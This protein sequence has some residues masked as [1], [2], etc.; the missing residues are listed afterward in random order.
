METYVNQ[1]QKFLRES[2]NVDDDDDDI[3]FEFKKPKYLQCFDTFGVD[4]HSEII[5]IRKEI[6]YDGSDDL[7][8]SLSTNIC[9]PKDTYRESVSEF[10]LSGQPLNTD[11][12]ESLLRCGTSIIQKD[13]IDDHV[14]L[15]EIEAR[16]ILS[17]A[18]MHLKPVKPLWILMEPCGQ[19]QIMI[20]CSVDGPCITRH[21]LKLT[22]EDTSVED[23]LG[24]HRS[25][26]SPNSKIDT[27]VMCDFTVTQLGERE[28]TANENNVGKITFQVFWREPSFKIPI[29]NSS[30][31]M[32]LHGTVGLQ[33]SAVQILWEQLELLHGYFE[34]LSKWNDSE[35]YPH[36]EQQKSVF[37]PHRICNSETNAPLSEKITSALNFSYDWYSGKNNEQ[38]LTSVLTELKSGE[39]QYSDVTDRLWLILTECTTHWELTN[40]MAFLLQGVKKVSTNTYMSADNHTRLGKAITTVKNDRNA[41]NPLFLLKPLQL[42]VEIGLLKLRR[43]YI[44]IFTDTLLAKTEALAVPEPPSFISMD[45]SSWSETVSSLLCWMAKVHAAL[46]LLCV[47]HSNLLVKKATIVSLTRQIL[48]KYVGSKSPIQSFTWLKNNPNLYLSAKMDRQS[49]NI[50]QD[51]KYDKWLMKLSTTENDNQYVETK[52][53]RTSEPMFPASVLHMRTKDDCTENTLLYLENA[54][55]TFSQMTTICSGLGSKKK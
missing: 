45:G 5:F 11:M 33:G 19:Q 36:A 16:S 50:P 48:E 46:E 34:L 13:K 14:P 29:T 44:T 25:Y 30:I 32:N 22:D 8:G 15:S 52:F 4:D 23:M 7:N 43:D 54:S 31:K 10:D 26:I 20:G 55:Y 40:N 39:R 38:T 28:S 42:L 35:S 27:E 12:N 51:P 18:C 24:I 21:V 37:L 2:L 49:S 17:Y 3:I 53:L 1:L 6:T 9:P 47:A 41:A